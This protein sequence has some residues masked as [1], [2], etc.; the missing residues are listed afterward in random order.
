MSTVATELRDEVAV[1]TLSLPAR[2]NALSR[3]LLDDLGDALIEAVDRGARAIVLTGAGTAFSAGADLDE[4]TGTVADVAIDDAVAA[5]TEALRACPAPVLA[6]IEGACV[7]AAVDL[8][9]ACD[10]RIIGADGY[11]SVPAVAL[12]ILYS[13]AALER[14]ASRA[15]QQTLARLLLFGERI[16]GADAVAAGL[17]ARAVADGTAVAAAVQLARGAAA[18]APEAAAT[19]KAVLAALADGSGFDPVD[20]EVARRELLGS[21]ARAERVRAAQDKH[22]RVR[23]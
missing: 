16:G 3:R 2:R 23:A 7:G 5:A 13:P 10:V 22:R 9:L 6:A 20:W 4:L 8:A 12:G 11:F 17:A 14:I 15:G 1:L 18:N 21:D 19:T